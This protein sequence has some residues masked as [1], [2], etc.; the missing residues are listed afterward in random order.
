[1]KCIFTFLLFSIIAQSEAQNKLPLIKATSIQAQIY[2]KDDP[3]SNW[4]INPKIKLDAHITGKLVK[5]SLIKFKTDIDSI[6]FRLKPGQYKD[7]LVLLNGKDTCLTRIQSPEVK[8]FSKLSPEVHDTIPFFVNKFNTNFIPV[9]FN[10]ADTL[11]MN[12]DTG[13]TEVSFTEDAL[14]QKIKSNPRLYSAFYNL[15]IGRGNFKSKIYDIR[16]AGNETDGLIGWDNFDG[17]IV[18]LD[19]DHN[20]MIVSSKMPGQI[21]KDHTYSK[22]KI[23]YFKNKPFIEGE[24]YQRDSKSKNWFLFD[25]GYQRT[26]MLD[27][28]LLKQAQFPVGDMKV[29]KK[30]IMHGIKGNEIPVIT[31]NLKMLKLGDYELVDVPAQLIG[32]NKPLRGASIHILG[33]D[34]LKRFNTVLDFQN[35]MIYLKANTLYR[36]AYAD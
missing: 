28:D 9:L 2:E 4:T 5:T 3:A 1:M 19:Y 36:T 12:F 17:M 13:A 26:A 7:F 8:N 10:N 30:V 11:M 29:I 32:Q 23:R 33:T 21:A 22:F 15:K 16:L 20:R 27:D 24:I 14:K 34:I 6:S 31:A 25:L 35:N 18:E